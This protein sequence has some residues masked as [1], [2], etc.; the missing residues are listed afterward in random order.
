[1]KKTLTWIIGIVVIL[2]VIAFLYNQ[3]GDTLFSHK[4]PVVIGIIQNVQHLD[5]I[6]D[7]FK[8]GLTEMGYEEGKD[9]IYEY[10][11]ANGDAGKAKEYAQELLGRG[12]VDLMYGVTSPV[13]QAI[14]NAEQEMG[15]TIPIV[16]SNGLGLVETGFL[17]SYQATG[18]NITGV[19]PDDVEV[20]VKK[21]EFLKQINPNA[22][23]VGVFVS[24]AIPQVYT[25]LALAGLREKAPSY[26]LDIKVYDIKQPPGPASTPAMQKLA[27]SIRPSELDAIITLPEVV[28]NFQENPTIL[29]EFSKRTGVPI[30]FLTV[31]RVYEGGLLSYSQD[32]AVYGRQIAAQADKI[33]KGANPGEIPLEFTQKNRLILNLKVAKELGLTIPASLLGI[34][35]EVVQ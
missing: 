11:N 34:A 8:D 30:L 1:M 29:L 15:S 27:D 31:P 24:T 25:D 26:G 19:L 33:L 13:V 7:G 9:V 20:T 4:E 22:K 5:P 6:V 17:D 14:W 28:S 10:R 32:Y 3:F 35:D 2:G 21:L 12:D 23:H 16:F 18:K